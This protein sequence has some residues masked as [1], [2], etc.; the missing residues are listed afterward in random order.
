M[1]DQRE[2][3]I[4]WRRENGPA[5]FELLAE[6]EL[7]PLLA[8]LDTALLRPRPDESSRDLVGRVLT[9]EAF[10][11]PERE[12]TLAQKLANVLL[13]DRLAAAIMGA[14][15]SGRPIVKVTP[16]PSTAAVPWEILALP[17]GRRLINIADIAYD[18][19]ATVKAKR[20]R[21][22]QSWADA[23]EGPV[24]YVLDPALP[25]NAGFGQVIGPPG[26]GAWQALDAILQQ[27]Q[28]SGL[29]RPADRAIAL[30]AIVTR[31]DLDE[32]LR[33]QP[34]SR[35]LY[36]GH[37]TAGEG[38]GQAALYLSDMTTATDDQ[39]PA[40]TTR[41][42]P[43]TALELFAGVIGDGRSDA[44]AAVTATPETEAEPFIGARPWPM[45]NRVAIIACASGS[46]FQ[47]LEPLG[48]V[49]AL[50]NSG[51]ELIT[52]TKWTIPS[53]AAFDIVSR[54][55][56][57]MAS[58][59]MALAVDKSHEAPDALSALAE[60]QR[61]QLQRWMAHGNIKHTPLL[62]AAL[63]TYVAP[64]MVNPSSQVTRTGGTQCSK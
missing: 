31:A 44:I 30:K 53:D 2:T 20:A 34:Y 33:A 36:L 18:V 52:A 51:V 47:S 55:T 1:S 26:Q 29:L 8:E 23:R 38:T 63:S 59:S 49:I 16:S 40:A 11:A 14:P 58:T 7:A 27:R 25:P 22:P 41:H 56:A 10:S 62:W 57:G 4:Y 6:A 45:P 37:A 46:D 60:W 61:S 32:R 39:Q 54:P 9:Q 35:L 19:P 28:Q 13:P 64:A 21:S 43:L 15:E 12:L 42:G 48:L 3:F 24:L 50:M 5:D 17:D